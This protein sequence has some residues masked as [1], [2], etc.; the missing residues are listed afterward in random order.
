MDFSVVYGP[1]GLR[2]GLTPRQEQVAQLLARGLNTVEIAEALD[3]VYNAAQM[4]VT[5]I[6]DKLPNPYHLSPLKLARQWAIAREFAR[7]GRE[8]PTVELTAGQECDIAVQIDGRS[9]TVRLS[10]DDSGELSAAV[11]PTEQG[12]GKLS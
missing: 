1:D 7:Q 3:I 11:E 12:D 9:R 5:A 2:K 8:M 4:H 6:A 10:A